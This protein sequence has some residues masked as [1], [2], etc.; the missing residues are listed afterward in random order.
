MALA[1][2]ARKAGTQPAICVE[3]LLVWPYIIQQI[4]NG[5]TDVI[6]SKKTSSR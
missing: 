5:Q 1:K 2:A 3:Y 4:Y 6:S